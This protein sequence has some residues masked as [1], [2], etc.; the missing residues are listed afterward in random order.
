V[1]LKKKWLNLLKKTGTLLR[2]YMQVSVSNQDL[3]GLIP[4]LHKPFQ[5]SSEEIIHVN[6]FY[7]P[8]IILVSNFL[9]MLVSEFSI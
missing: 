6:L 4:N 2:K 8:E 9:S 5:R 1:I 3:K 7:E